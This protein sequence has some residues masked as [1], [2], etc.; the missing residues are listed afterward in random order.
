MLP[1][2]IQSNPTK[3]MKK[4]F[5]IVLFLSPFLPLRAQVK[6]GDNPSSINPNSLLELESTNKGFLPP[7]VALNNAASVAP[8]SGTVPAGMLVFSSGGS[9]A[10]GYYYWDGSNWK[11]LTTNNNTVVSKSA[12]ATLTK[13][14]N[15]VLARNDIII[16]LPSV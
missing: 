13:T 9:L 3:N 15:I 5:T 2:H 6:I 7:R 14:E 1:D 4:L 10:D 16:T 12:N 11:L 8:L